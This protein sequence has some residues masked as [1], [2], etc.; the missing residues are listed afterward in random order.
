V[1]D[2][3][4]IEAFYKEEIKLSAKA[5][6]TLKQFKKVAVFAAVQ[7]IKLDT[8]IKQLKELNIE[9]LTTHGKRTSGENQLLGC[10]CFETSFQNQD[11]FD[12]ADAILYVGDGLFH[13]KAMVL[14]QKGS[15]NPKDVIL[16]DPISDTVKQIG[17]KDI[18]L[19][20]K[21]YKANLMR[22]MSAEKV[23][24]LVS[25]KTGQQYLQNALKFKKNSDKQVYIFVGDTLN[26]A[27]MENFPFIEVW[28]NTACPRI[29]YDDVT[30][31]PKPL[32]NI[33]DA[34][35]PEQ[36]LIQFK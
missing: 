5:I 31:M 14:A 16:F 17:Q 27:D 25:T 21:K 6:K 28:I 2:F 10:D 29:G 36:S 24:V 20:L 9:P 1:V 18:D 8:V 11:I 26:Y 12:E 35:T 22:Y 15:D 34:T 32:I 33:N 3:L 30:N 4:L 23:G 19:Q 13:P 7:F